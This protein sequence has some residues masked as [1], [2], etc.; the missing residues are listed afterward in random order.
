LRSRLFA[1]NVEGESPEDSGNSI[2]HCYEILNRLL[3]FFIGHRMHHVHNLAKS[4]FSMTPLGIHL[5]NLVI[6][7]VARPL[8]QTVDSHQ[9]FLSLI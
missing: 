9:R 5:T 7:R 2:S 8:P 6:S 4:R 1:P 3:G